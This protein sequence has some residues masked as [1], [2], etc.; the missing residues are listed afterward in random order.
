MSASPVHVGVHRSRSALYDTAL[1]REVL[2]SNLEERDAYM[3]V[4]RVLNGMIQQ[5][6]SASKTER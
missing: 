5:V 2:Q 6:S 3:K 1:D 4:S